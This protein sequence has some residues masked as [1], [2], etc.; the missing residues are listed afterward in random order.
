MRNSENWFT[1]DRLGCVNAAAHR[2]RCKYITA[3]HGVWV[4]LD[5]ST[6]QEQR[7]LSYSIQTATNG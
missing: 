4:A 6:Q 2:V 5:V 7:T 1:P 3:D